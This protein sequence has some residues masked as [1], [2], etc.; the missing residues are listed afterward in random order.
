[1]PV[2]FGDERWSDGT[3]AGAEG[4]SPMSVTTRSPSH[5]GTV[6]RAVLAG[7]ITLA[8]AAAA[9]PPSAAASTP[10]S[11]VTPLAY[12]AL[13]DSYSA[14]SFVRPW[15]G[16]GCG[17]SEINY[18]KQVGHR[19]KVSLKDVTCGA[20]EVRA[21]VL[22]PQT[23]LSGPPTV[24]P[25]GGWKARPAQIE[26]VTADT[27]LVSVGIGGNSIGFAGIVQQCVE[28]GLRAFGLGHPCADHY[29]KGEGAAALDR[30]FTTMERDVASMLDGIHARAPRAG[31]AVVGYP[32][33]VD[34]GSGCG[35]GVWHQLGTITRG[36]MTW[37]DSLERR[38]NT[39][40]R[41]QSAR[42][43][44]RYVDTYASSVGHGVC[45]SA[46]T[47]WMYGLKDHLTGEGTQG[48]PPADICRLIPADGEAACTFLHPNLRGATHQADDVTKALLA[49]GA[50]PRT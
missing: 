35:L 11:A 2:T 34:D 14:N 48:D 32:A 16:G 4:Q 7:V 27:S 47:R 21:G 15:A 24:P 40:L 44:V 5:G 46:E 30:R 49:L 1:M 8:A 29:T 22:E 31:I 9:F 50:A 12:V 23:R 6:R 33:I 43:H 18:P 26:A 41:D 13:G 17:Q 19:L 42:A 3:C 25:A 20:A 38:L 45:A 36:D 10:V 28:R 37:M 39:A